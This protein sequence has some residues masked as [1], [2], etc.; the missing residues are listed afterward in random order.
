MGTWG[1]QRRFGAVEVARKPASGSEVIMRIEEAGV[2]LGRARKGR[3]RICHPIQASQS[4]SELIVR[5][6]VPGLRPNGAFVR[7]GRARE[8]A[9]RFEDPAEGQQR[10]RG[11]G[12][13]AEHPFE[14]VL[15]RF[16]SARC[17]ELPGLSHGRGHVSITTSL[18]R[19]LGCADRSR[20]ADSHEAEER[21]RRILTSV[22]PRNYFIRLS[23]IDAQNRG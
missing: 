3:N 15:R 7:A 18:G 1:A 5:D 16:E 4:E 14:R 9:A 11:I 23:C 21:H 20:H 12:L 2:Q 6:G 10:F 22:T 13:P 8:M 19:T 17:L